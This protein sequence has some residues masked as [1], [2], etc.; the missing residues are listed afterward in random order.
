[1]IRI[2]PFLTF[3]TMLALPA[4]AQTA[5]DAF[6]RIDRPSAQAPAP[7]GRHSAGCAAGLVALPETG[8]SWQ[9]M[10]LSRN[11]NWGHPEMVDM[12]QQL[13][14][15]MDRI[16]WGGIYVGDLSAPRGGPISGHASH[17]I[18]LDAD[19]W[20]Y[21]ATDMT[22]SRQRRESLSAISMRRAAGAFVNDNWTRGQHELV[23]RAAQDPRTT[24]IFI[25]PGAKVRMCEDETGDRA[26]LSKVRPW[27]GHHYHMHVRISCPVGARGCV[28]QDPPPPGDGCAEARDWVARILDPPPPDP[29][30][31]PPRPRRALTMADL[32]PQCTSILSAPSR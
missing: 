9:A 19:I 16:G 18:G 22:L 12:V 17:Q 27:Y 24:R 30:A 3:L 2:A 14:R 5:Q 1:M 11:R 4:G 23:K 8:P 20:L 10:R 29:D 6:A 21:P 7:L 25:F 32:P 26:W 28:N 31:P 13:G 15:H